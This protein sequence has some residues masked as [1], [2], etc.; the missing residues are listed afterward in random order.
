MSAEKKY[1]CRF[2][3]PEC[4]YNS[5]NTPTKVFMSVPENPKRR[6]LWFSLAQRSDTPTKFSSSFIIIWTF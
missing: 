6:K 2:F 3:V 5:E 4:E 1:I